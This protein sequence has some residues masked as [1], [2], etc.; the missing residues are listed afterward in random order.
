MNQAEIARAIECMR[1]DGFSDKEIEEELEVT[2]E[3]K[4]DPTIEDAEWVSCS[5]CDMLPGDA[6]KLSAEDVEAGMIVHAAR[7]DHV[8][9]FADLV[10]R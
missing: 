9:K 3:R 6:C 2:V 7:F 5:E 4:N 8:R 10:D 1:E